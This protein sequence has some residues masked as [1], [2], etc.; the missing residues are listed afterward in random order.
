MRAVD[1]RGESLIEI[2]IAT[3]IMGVA[4]VAVLGSVGVGVLMSDVHRKQATAG[5]SVRSYAEQLQAWVAAGG[6]QPCGSDSAYGAWAGYTAPTSYTRS[7]VAGSVRYWNGT[8]WVTSC[9]ASTD[10]GLQQL[11]LQVAS[12][13][14]RA[15]ERLTLTLR[16][17]CGL[18]DALC[19]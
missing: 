7:V 4:L 17:R 11:T 5:A 18:A 9:S 16:K 8:A 19:G 2:L 1:D 15:S 10:Q 12:D 3:A 6:Y 14:G 13:D